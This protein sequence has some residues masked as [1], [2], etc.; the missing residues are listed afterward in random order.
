MANRTYKAALRQGS[1]ASPGS[2]R[3]S[4]TIKEADFQALR[5]VADKKH[6]TIGGTAADLIRAA[7]KTTTAEGQR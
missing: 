1:K 5:A 7:L 3:V 4:V 6:Q 2:K